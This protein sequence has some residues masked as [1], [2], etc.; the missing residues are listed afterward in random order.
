MQRNVSP[1]KLYDYCGHLTQ[2]RPVNHIIS[3]PEPTPRP[4]PESQQPSAAP[5]LVDPPPSANV[6]GFHSHVEQRPERSFEL[7][8]ERADPLGPRQ[9]VE[10]RRDTQA[11]NAR[12]I[13]TMPGVLVAGMSSQD[14]V[15]AL[16]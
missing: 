15:E 3:P 12:L 13:A 16:L 4:H 5:P 6:P 9:V 2:D 11:A 7:P 14:Q 1:L 10:D 8:I